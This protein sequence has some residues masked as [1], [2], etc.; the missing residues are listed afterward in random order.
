M[1]SFQFCKVRFYGHQ[2]V[3]LSQIAG[4][5]VGS[6]LLPAEPSARPHFA[7]AGHSQGC[8]WI[9]GSS[10][11]RICPKCCVRNTVQPGSLVRRSRPPS[12]MTAPRCGGDNSH[13]NS[14][15]KRKATTSRG[16]DL[17]RSFDGSRVVHFHLRL[18]SLTLVAFFIASGV[19]VSKSFLC[20]PY[21]NDGLNLQP[22]A[23]E[24]AVVGC[25]TDKL[26]HPAEVN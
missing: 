13:K 2:E 26:R 25:G 9:P 15:K 7:T 16:H 6:R 4:P 12:T 11:T 22:L 1:P 18:V 5:S 20:G 19:I 3:L 10:R 8:A 21:L 14:L 24:V 23:V 17:Y